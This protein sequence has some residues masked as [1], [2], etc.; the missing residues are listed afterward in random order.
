M[1][2]RTLSWPLTERSGSQASWA[3]AGFK[4]ACQRPHVGLANTAGNEYR[5]PPGARREM[6][7]YDMPLL[8]GEEESYFGEA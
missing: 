1:P 6:S 2:E 7:V 3:A 5:A 8:L 4:R